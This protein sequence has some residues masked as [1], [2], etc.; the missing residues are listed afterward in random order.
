M[1][2]HREVPDPAAESRPLS[3]LNSLDNAVI[4]FWV[5]GKAATA[6]DCGEVISPRTGTAIAQFAIPTAADIEAA[7][8]A[9]A[10]VAKTFREISVEVRIAALEQ[11]ASQLET[12]FVDVAGIISA[13]TGKPA[14]WARA[15]TN[16]AISAL[17]IA[18]QAT[19]KFG[20]E[21][22][23]LAADK[24]GRS[25]R[26]IIRRFP[27]G[28]ILGIA[29]FNFPLNLVV[30]KLAPAIAVGAP[31]I[32]KPSPRTPASA[33]LLGR[34]VSE[35]DLPAGVVSVLPVGADSTMQLVKDPR[36]PVVSFTGSDIVGRSIVTAAPEK[37]I[38]L[39]LGG[40]AAAIVCADF[41]SEAD[42]DWVTDRIA[43]FANY[44]AGQS[45]I[46]VQ[47]VLIH[48]SLVAELTRRL[49]ERIRAMA[50]SSVDSIVGPVID[51]QSGARIQQWLDDAV[52]RGATVL[53]GGTSQGAFV[54][55]TL[56]T[57]VPADSTLANNEVFGPV[58]YLS[59]F[60]DLAD[61]FAKVN[62]SRFGLQCGIFTHNREVA[63]S[64]F[65][66][67]E[68]GGLIVGDVPSFRADE[69]PYGGVKE[70]G[71]GREGVRSAMMD[72]TEERVMV[73]TDFA[74]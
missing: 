56:L 65:R 59:S 33:E 72:Y 52:A 54:E 25:R 7:V 44:Q 1:G 42:L 32:I 24:S 55:P 8:A 21:Q 47:R 34:I 11:I 43:T 31:I 15:E 26:A 60:T 67:L 73:L 49:T 3:G 18:A 53:A 30:H 35:T 61:A 57:D 45:C 39:E 12:D 69:M 13:E 29:P 38:T 22:L 46:S 19:A 41:N 28:P 58:M 5:A 27:R 4:P 16:R 68:V 23:E 40:D 70:S 9:A 50:A 62:S 66:E 14:I 10:A 71:R 51:P 63:E 20:D 17:R 48:E 36:L 64:A 2:N 74:V 37:H 6:G